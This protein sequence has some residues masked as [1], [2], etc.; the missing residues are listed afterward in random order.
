[1]RDT[2]AAP[3]LAFAREDLSVWDEARELI[4]ANHAETGALPGADFAPDRP[5]YEA[6]ER[7]G[8]LRVFTARAAGGRLAGYALFVLGF[9]LHYPSV[10]FAMQ[11]TLFLD[12]LHRRGREGLR[13]IDWQDAAFRADGVH[14]VYRHVTV[15]CDYS[16][17]LARMGYRPE[18][19]RFIRDLREQAA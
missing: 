2:E 9:H 16:R 10:L 6:I 3:S 4:D 5:R 12:A 7:N 11:D 19:M 15:R 1:M 8:V 17:G 13:F 14:V 18:E